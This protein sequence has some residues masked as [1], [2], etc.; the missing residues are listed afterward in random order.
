MGSQFLVTNIFS[1]IGQIKSPNFPTKSTKA[2]EKSESPKIDI[3]TRKRR[4]ALTKEVA[5][6]LDSL[7][8]VEMI[9]TK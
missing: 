1:F 7:A 4:S 5:S 2:E 9:E 8:L 3:E 6:F